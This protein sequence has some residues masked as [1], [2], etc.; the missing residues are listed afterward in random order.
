MAFKKYIRRGGKV[1]GPYLYENK[2]V[3]DKIVTTYL[4]QGKKDTGE[5][6]ING[7][8]NF[9]YYF[10][11]F[12]ALILII[13]LLIYL[14][15]LELSGRAVG[16]NC[17]VGCDNPSP[18]GTGENAPLI[19]PDVQNGDSGGSGN[20]YEPVEISVSPGETILTANVPVRFSVPESAGLS[21]GNV[22]VREPKGSSIALVQ[23]DLSEWQ[24]NFEVEEGSSIEKIDLELPPSRFARVVSKNKTKQTKVSINPNIIEN[25]FFDSVVSS[26]DL[27]IE[28]PSGEY[29]LLFFMEGPYV[30]EIEETNT[31]QVG[32]VSNPV[33]VVY[34]DVAV[35]VPVTFN[36]DDTE[37]IKINVGGVE[38][39]EPIFFDV[40]EDGTEDYVEFKINEI[41]ENSEKPFEIVSRKGIRSKGIDVL[42]DSVPEVRPQDIED[43]EVSCGN[44][45]SCNVPTES[46]FGK[47]TFV[48]REG[49]STC[50]VTGESTL[51]NPNNDNSNCLPVYYVTEPCDNNDFVEPVTVVESPGNDLFLG[52]GEY[53]KDVEFKQ[54]DIVSEIDRR[55]VVVITKTNGLHMTFLQESEGGVALSPGSCYDGVQNLEESGIDCGGLCKNCALIKK[56]KDFG[57]VWWINL[58]L[59]LIFFIFI[60]KTGSKS[61]I[62]KLIRNGRKALAEKDIRKALMNY[63]S[64]EN[65]FTGLTP[66][67]KNSVR[68]ECLRYHIRLRK[69]LEKRDIKVKSTASTNKL[70]SLSFRKEDVFENKS[71]NDIERIKRIIRRGEESLKKSKKKE[72]RSDYRVVRKI[73]DGL[74]NADKK[75]VKGVYGSFVRKFRH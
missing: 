23:K 52:P 37:N 10:L 60:Q 62:I 61:K 56:K 31:G 64:I 48:E 71:H 47:E 54:V 40:D 63:D 53:A 30:K 42:R 1:Y 65:M 8:I 45:K 32:I 49:T 69:F 21:I 59:L 75:K 38:V 16:E 41:E 15:N 51:D 29:S 55:R 67:E 39:E 2:R 12:I 3:G 73:Y 70:P 20:P 13:F 33:D 34:R 50:L 11:G 74:D 19:G 68:Q 22:I 58:A 28:E 57:W 7:K 46:I 9:R 27:T 18:S 17:L 26:V 25:N 35:V 66:Q 5:S 43:C 6:Q 36:L 14:N 72:A 24:V 4:G 44:Y